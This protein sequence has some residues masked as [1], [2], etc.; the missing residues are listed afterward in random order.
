MIHGP[1]IPLA[2]LKAIPPEHHRMIEYQAAM[3]QFAE[4]VRSK[5]FEHA[6]T[7]SAVVQTYAFHLF[8]KLATASAPDFDQLQ[9]EGRRTCYW[10][11]AE[12]FDGLNLK[13]NP[14]SLIV[15][16]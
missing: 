12:P 10:S 6:Q 14:T 3:I 7:L 4:H 16:S 13:T 9:T 11:L 15:P 1:A 5:H 8:G 2:H